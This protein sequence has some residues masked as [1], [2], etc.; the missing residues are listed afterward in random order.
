MTIQPLNDRV[1]IINDDG[2]PTQYFIRMLKERGITVDEKITAEQAVALIEQ[3]A[4][5]RDINV[6]SPINGGG[7]LSSDVTIGMEDSPV[8]PGS[9]TNTDLTVDQFGRIT[10]AANGSGGGG[11]GGLTLLSEVVVTS[12]TASVPFVSLITPTYRNYILEVASLVPVTTGTYLNMR[13]STNNGVSYD[14]AGNYDFAIWQSNQASFAST[15]G[16][17]SAQ[18]ALRIMHDMTNSANN[19]SNGRFTL[20]NPNGTTGWKGVNGIAQSFS[21]DGNFYLRTQAGNWRNAAAYNAFQ[22]FMNSGN[23]ASGIFRLYGEA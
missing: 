8:T 13:M 17:G 4:S 15:I 20:Y 19:S 11:G 12:S 3:W 5:A 1:P 22:L 10:A 7:P 6:T 18:T 21:T 2:T 23:I 14:T 9:Y 16:G